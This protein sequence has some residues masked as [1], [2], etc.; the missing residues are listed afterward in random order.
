MKEGED[1]EKGKGKKK[2]NSKKTRVG[3]HYLDIKRTTEKSIDRMM[4]ESGSSMQREAW[5]GRKPFF[6]ELNLTLNQERVLFGL[7]ALQEKKRKRCCNVRATEFY[8][9]MGLKKTSNGG[10]SKF[11][12]KQMDRALLQLNSILITIAYRSKEK[13]YDGVVRKTLVFN[14]ATALVEVTYVGSNDERATTQDEMGDHVMRNLRYIRI[15]LKA[16][17]V[18]DIDNYYRLIP[19]TLY[20]DIKYYNQKRGRRT[21]VQEPRF[22]EW[23]FAKRKDEVKVNRHLVFSLRKEPFNKSRLLHNGSSPALL[24]IVLDIFVES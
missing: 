13:G 9:A 19:S 10:Y 24:I 5:E 14:P 7:W 12:T 23:L 17:L 1:K 16:Q 3:G 15:A 2:K 4:K 22:I 11:E 18:A 20:E 6:S 8:E 21:V